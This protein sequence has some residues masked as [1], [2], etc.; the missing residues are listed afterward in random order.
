MAEESTARKGG[1][2]EGSGPQVGWSE[3]FE[4]TYVVRFSHYAKGKGR[5][6]GR[7]REAR[8]YELAAGKTLRYWCFFYGLGHGQRSAGSLANLD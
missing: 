2:K 3:S 8:S 5:E 1:Q 6:L 7:D 4:V